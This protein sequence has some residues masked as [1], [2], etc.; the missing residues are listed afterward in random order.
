M[1][2]RR[3]RAEALQRAEVELAGVAGERDKGVRAVGRLGGELRGLKEA[4][5][6]P[7]VGPR[8]ERVLPLVARKHELGAERA[9]L[10]ARCDG[11]REALKVEAASAAA[12]AE[13]ASQLD[14]GDEALVAEH[15]ACASRTREMQ[16]ELSKASRAALFLRRTLDDIPN[17]NELTQYQRR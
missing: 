9:A 13:R 5:R 14:Q 3:R 15:D 11:E 10:K 4:A 12:A 1:A 16:K 7:E 17:S 8:L 2:C 6:D